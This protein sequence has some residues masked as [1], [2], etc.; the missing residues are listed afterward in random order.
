ML[1]LGFLYKKQGAFN[2][3]IETLSETEPELADYILETRKWSERLISMRNELHTVW[4][5]SKME[6]KNNSGTIEVVEPQ[7]AGEP[8]SK[9]VNYM[10]DRLC[11]FVEDISVYGLETI[12]PS[13]ISV[14]EIPISKRKTDC[15]E[16][17]QVTFV[18]GG[19]QIWTIA[20]HDSKFED[21]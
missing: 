19:M 10:I 6:Y 2:N 9:F 4:M 18:N 13:G 16:R 12:M 3:G 1:E 14:T 20:Y 21:T 5:L 15:P 11:C 7:I 17:F 8:V